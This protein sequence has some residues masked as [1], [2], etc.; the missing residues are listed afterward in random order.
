MSVARLDCLI[1]DT[2]GAQLPLDPAAHLPL[3]VVLLL[4][5]DQIGERCDRLVDQRGQVAVGGIVGGAPVLHPAR[6]LLLQQAVDG[7]TAR[8]EIHVLGLALLAPQFLPQVAEQLELLGRIQLLLAPLLDDLLQPL[9]QRL[10]EDRVLLHADVDFV[11]DGMLHLARLGVVGG[12]RLD[13]LVEL[14]RE[15]LHLLDQDLDAVGDDGVRDQ[16]PHLLAAAREVEPVVPVAGAGG[17]PDLAQP[18]EVGVIRRGALV[19]QQHVHRLAEAAER[20]V[21]GGPHVL[22]LQHPHAGVQVVRVRDRLEELHRRRVAGLQPRQLVHV[23]RQRALDVGGRENGQRVLQLRGHAPVVDDQAVGLLVPERAVHA[24]DGLQ[25]PVLLQ[26]LVEIHD[27][28][29]RR[30]ETGQQH[31]AHHQDGQRIV[32]ILEPVDGLLLLVL[33]QMPL[34]QALLVVVAGRHDDHRLGPFSRSSV[35]L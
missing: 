5:V 21:E 31:V 15:E 28:L 23:R 7:E 3:H 8:V 18:A 2:A 1:V 17:A 16:L 13:L 22:G 10:V 33:A 27:L 9:A 14:L 35:S 6:A 29:D 20:E 4:P 24:G 12:E 19:R 11:A 34:R 32:P 26:R 30:V 25:Q